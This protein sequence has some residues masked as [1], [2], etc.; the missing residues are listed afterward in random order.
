VLAGLLSDAGG[1]NRLGGEESDAEQPVKPTIRPAPMASREMSAR[2]CEYCRTLL[3]KNPDKIV[4]D[5]LAICSRIVKIFL[6]LKLMAAPSTAQF[7]GCFA[8]QTTKS[9]SAAKPQPVQR[10][11][12]HNEGP[13]AAEPQPQIGGYL[14]QRH[15]GAKKNES[16]A[17][18]GCCV[19]C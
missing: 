3:L 9:L 15:K 16:F 10:R 2:K 13:S 6:R 18:R 1:E 14:A 5:I 4:W 8:D 12:F 7:C 19:S 11:K 17:F